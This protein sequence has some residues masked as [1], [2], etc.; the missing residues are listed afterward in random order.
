MA[1]SIG[2]RNEPLNENDELH[3]PKITLELVLNTNF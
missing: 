3:V 1:T 2:M